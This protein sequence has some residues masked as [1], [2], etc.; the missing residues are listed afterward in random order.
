MTQ[1][2]PAG[3]AC[4]AVLGVPHRMLAAGTPL[5]I[6]FTTFPLLENISCPRLGAQASWHPG[7]LLPRPAK[8]GAPAQSGGTQREGSRPA[9]HSGP[10]RKEAAGTV[11]STWTLR[12]PCPKTGVLQDWYGEAETVLAAGK[13]KPAVLGAGARL[14]EKS[15][16]E[17]ARLVRAGARVAQ[18]TPG[19]ASLSSPL[20]A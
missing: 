11:L 19:P 15:G 20:T 9:A 1:P 18:N 17:E 16:G 6:Q 2:Q 14:R 8:T 10:P 12:E 13:E 4:Q 3:R 5:F 7:S